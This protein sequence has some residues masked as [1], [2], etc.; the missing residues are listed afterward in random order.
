M[1][2]TPIP[3]LREI[4]QRCGAARSTVG[5]I[6]GGRSHLFKP[7]TRDL[8]LKAAEEMGW[9]RPSDWRSVRRARFGCAVMLQ[10]TFGDRSV[11]SRNYLAALED[12]L[13]DH[14]MHLTLARLP[15]ETLASET[16][17]RRL[18]H[19][20]SADGLLVSY[21]QAAP[22]RMRDLI[23]GLGLPAIW[24]NSVE[25]LDAVRPDDRGAGRR[26][27]ELLL[28]VGHR[29]IAYVGFAIPPSYR[30]EHIHYS[31]RERPAGAREAVTAAGGD[32]MEVDGDD[33]NR[34]DTWLRRL[35]KRNRET[36][37][38]CY[39]PL[40]VQTVLHAALVLG[41]DVP[42]DL[43]LITFHDDT[44]WML[45]REIASL[46]LPNEKQAEITVRLLCDR[47]AGDP[48]QVVEPVPFVLHS[49]ASIAPPRTRRSGQRK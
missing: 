24:M 31:M 2:Y 37:I 21:T 5:H 45:E 40:Q 25:A 19:Q 18:L 16:G 4:A 46:N 26:A 8:V 35:R 29:R 6:L 15:D 47:I 17:L 20:W 10:S 27:A 1:P 44:V 38:I 12:R 32:W 41:L 33:G 36:A 14:N 11:I 39:C 9:K 34:I 7:A 22:K 3:S 42:G 49:R 48:P 23:T 13:L 28:E 30:E 43:S